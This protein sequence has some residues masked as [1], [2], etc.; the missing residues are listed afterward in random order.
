MPRTLNTC[1]VC[2][3]LMELDPEID[4][5]ETGFYLLVC[6]ECGTYKKVWAYAQMI[7]GGNYEH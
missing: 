5:T 6:R 4:P 1:E 2:S 3:S 7:D